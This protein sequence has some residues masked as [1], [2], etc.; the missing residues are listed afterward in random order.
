M[1]ENTDAKTGESELA[2]RAIWA[3]RRPGAGA[4]CTRCGGAELSY[5]RTFATGS[6][7]VFRTLIEDVYCLICGHM[8]QPDYRLEERAK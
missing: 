1:A 5:V 6:G 3:P 4:R 7:I 2:G 8:G